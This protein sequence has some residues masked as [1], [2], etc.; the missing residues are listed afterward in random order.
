VADPNTPEEWLSLAD[1][2][3]ATALAV[4]G[5]RLAAGQA[6]FHA[7]LAVE[8]ALKAYIMRRERLNG[9]PS[10]D[11]RPE[12]YVHDLR[13]LREMAGIA[14]GSRDPQTPS[15]HLFLQW[16]RS[17]GYDPKPM[18]RKVAKAW[19]EAAFGPAGLVTWIRQ[20]SP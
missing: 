7:G 5:H 4:V 16:D 2:H 19:I 20:N 13:K 3:Q 11:T 12:L 15:W 9:W 14:I 6:M 17:Q 18:P 8:C 10:R 1:Q